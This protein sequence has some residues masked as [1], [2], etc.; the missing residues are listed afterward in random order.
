MPNTSSIRP[1]VLIKHRLV[2]E[3]QT[4]TDTDTIDAGCHAA[5]LAELA[6]S[7]LRYNGNLLLRPIING[8]L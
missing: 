6:R 3:R 7:K 1:S 4:Q 8:Y 2:T 5:C